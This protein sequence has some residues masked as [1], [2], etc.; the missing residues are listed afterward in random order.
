[1][2]FPSCGIQL[3]GS[4]GSHSVSIC[5]HLT[6]SNS[7]A[8]ILFV[9][10][11]EWGFNLEYSVSRAASLRTH[12][13][14]TTNNTFHLQSICL[15][16]KSSSVDLSGDAGSHYF[17]LLFWANF[18]LFSFGPEKRG[19]RP[20]QGSA[21]SAFPP[22]RLYIFMSFLSDELLA[23]RVCKFTQIYGSRPRLHHCAIFQ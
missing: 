3:T 21:F 20:T 14:T 9:G 22:P 10:V 12:R 18:L 7:L 13:R 1:M 15:S 17:A 5:T 8:G 23:P 16:A 11:V 2:Y 19:V 4:G 6:L